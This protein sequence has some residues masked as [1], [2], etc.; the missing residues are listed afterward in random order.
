[1]SPIGCT[2]IRVLGLS[3]AVLHLNLRVQSSLHHRV[4]HVP[5][6][7]SVCQ[8][9]MVSET[10]EAEWQQ[11]SRL[12]DSKGSMPILPEDAVNCYMH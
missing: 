12:L 8:P 3:L 5:C 1:M 11:I 4:T 10:I 2:P 7:T 6:V 9:G